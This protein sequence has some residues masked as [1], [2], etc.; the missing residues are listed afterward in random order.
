MFF[1][2]K[3]KPTQTQIKPDEIVVDT[4]KIKEFLEVVETISGSNLMHKIDS[5]KLRL[6]NYCKNREIPSFQKVISLIKTDEKTKQDIMNLITV[7]ET[8]FY[9]EIAQ[10]REVISYAS[11]LN[12]PK[13]LCAP[14]SSGDEVYSL[15]MLSAQNGL[16]N[17]EITGIDINSIAI[18]EAIDGIYDERHL[19]RLDDE[20]KQ[21]FFEKG[22]KSYKIKTEILP[23][24]EFKVA[25]IFDD[26]ISSLGKFDI[27][28]SRNMMIYFN[29]EFRLKCVENLSKLLKPSGRF[30]VGHADLMPET[31][32]FSK[33]FVN[34]II[35]Y[36]K[37]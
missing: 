8:Y 18:E 22:E 21:I 25:N 32:I 29:E 4:S 30:Y 28:L 14:C 36:Q 27:V 35:Y 6:E 16:R 19:H 23:K 5:I 10:L 37:V 17:I 9:R 3:I 31:D 12:S 26:K 33:E 11:S 34:S 24:F 7:N 13:I 15:C 2:K 1:R 20:L